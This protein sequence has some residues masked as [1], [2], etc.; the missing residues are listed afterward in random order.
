MGEYAESISSTV[1]S[2]IGD[3]ISSKTLELTNRIVELE[4]ELK[5]RPTKADVE[6]SLKVHQ[7]AN[8][9]SR[10]IILSLE[11]RIE[12]LEDKVN[13]LE[14]TIAKQTG[15]TPPTVRTKLLC[16]YLKTYACNN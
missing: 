5:T 15:R 16:F 10:D 12:E 14:E 7:H 9:T 4:F 1:A 13:E 11:R 3:A 8:E 2:L 6:T